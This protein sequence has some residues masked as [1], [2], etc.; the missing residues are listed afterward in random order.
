M[1]FVKN[2]DIMVIASYVNVVDNL[3]KLPEVKKL[4][5]HSTLL[6]DAHFSDYEGTRVKKL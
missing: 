1:V 6:W 5:P 2:N 3:L 4:I